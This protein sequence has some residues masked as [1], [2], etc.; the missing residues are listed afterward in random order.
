M[1][2]NIF[3]SIGLSSNEKARL[4]PTHLGLVVIGRLPQVT[5]GVKRHPDCAVRAFLVR[6]HQARIARHIGG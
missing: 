3:M 5:I 6:P 4:Q 2:A 1:S